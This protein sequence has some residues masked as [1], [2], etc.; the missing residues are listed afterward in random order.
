MDAD[1]C[2]GP[3][4][5]NTKDSKTIEELKNE[6]NIFNESNLVLNYGLDNET[7]KEPCAIE[8]GKKNT[9]AIIYLL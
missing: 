7:H 4:T 6:S 8:K 2:E 1:E 9:V 3:I 5:I